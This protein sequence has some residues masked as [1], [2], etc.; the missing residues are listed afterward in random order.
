MKKQLL[1]LVMILLPM[2]VS[3]YDIKIDGIY[4]NLIQKAN[5]VEVTSG[6]NLYLGDVI[7]PDHIK[8]NEVD[9]PVASIG[10]EAFY[11]CTD[12]TSVFIPNSITT[13][14]V[15]A[16]DHCT[17]LSSL[18]L[19]IS[20]TSIGSGAF[21]AC[22]GL[23][24]IEIPNSVTAIGYSAFNACKGLTSVVLPNSISSI[25][26]YTFCGCSNLCSIDIPSS[27]TS[28]G[29]KA[30]QGCASLTS[31]TIPDL[32]TAI[33]YYTFQGC[34]SLTSVTIGSSVQQIEEGAFLNCIGL[35]FLNIPSSVTSIGYNAFGECTGITS[36]TIPN[37]VKDIGIHAF[38]GCSSLRTVTIGSSIN[39]INNFAFANCSVLTDVYC[40]KKTV[41]STSSNA[42]ENSYIEYATLH[43]PVASINSYQASVPWKNFNK[44]VK[45]D[46]PQ[47][48]LTYLLD[49]EVYITYQLEEGESVTPEAA[50]TKEGY[51]FSGWSEIPATMPAHDVTVTGTFSI[52]KYKLT[53]TVDG[54]EY[55][56]S[57]VEYGA[58]ITPEAAPTKDGCT[59]SGW[60]EIPATMPAHDVTVTGSFSLNKYKLT[61]IVDGAEYKTYEIEYG[62]II[63]P[64]ETPTKEGYTFSGWS[65]IPETMPAYDVTITGSFSI[66]KYKLTYMIDD[67][68]YKETMYEYGATIT[69]EPQPE[70]DY[71][72]F[73]WTDLPQTMPAHD[74][75]VH[76]SYT[77][78]IIEVLMASQHNVRIYSP[79]GKKL[80]KLQKGLNI[81]IID[82][83]TVKKVIVK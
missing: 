68:V 67:K 83:G 41:P 45:I 59:F 31:I 35:V 44:I 74:V 51:T 73:E 57:E 46:M 3:A 49:G 22:V 14:G 61:Y 16:F 24:S 7:I 66:N 54:E 21:N 17:S 76:A 10:K 30:F 32:V 39:N 15:Q 1:L 37:S 40:Y 58:T 9:Y 26:D 42:F 80:N 20:L 19:P 13:I 53:Y 82:D 63:K 62:A 52:N 12:L 55:K 50:P 64:E 60:S 65:E 5:I 79:N 25:E 27:V 28:L 81:V 75:V 47:Y 6:D 78:G 56:S 2:V 38:N 70:G 72:T 34:T 8:Y 43:V 48:T 11:Y 36:I 4:Y 18:N 71:A 29:Q 33:K 69:P 77:S 23:N